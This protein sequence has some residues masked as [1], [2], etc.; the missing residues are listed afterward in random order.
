LSELYSLLSNPARLAV[1]GAAAVVGSML[2]PW[3]GIA[4]LSLSRT[5]FDSFG[6]GQLALLI[7][8]GAAAYLM[9]RC[10]RGYRPPRPL[11]EGTLV[12]LAGAWSALLVGYL[13][14]DRP[15][16]I[17]GFSH[18]HLRYGIYIA[19]GGAIA[20]LVGG[21]RLRRDRIA[22]AEPPA[23]GPYGM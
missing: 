17:A 13:I 14:I 19:M 5:G 3:Y 4:Y 7:T 8:V 12:A 20:M 6:L 11:D 1:I 9:A 18:I 21:L 22:A 23:A 16:Q 2:L 15:N 10:A